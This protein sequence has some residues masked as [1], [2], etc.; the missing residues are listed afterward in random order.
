MEAI[1]QSHRTLRFGVFDVDLRTAELRKHG[2][3]IRLEEQPFH[4]LTLLLEC[5]GELVTREELRQRL[6]SADTFVDFDRSLNKAM[7]KLRLALGDSAESPRYIETLHRRGYRFIAPI[8]HDEPAGAHAVAHDSDPGLR[9][10]ASPS[11]LVPAASG[12]VAGPVGLNSAWRLRRGYWMAALTVV[13]V[14]V[15]TVFYL[16]ARPVTL[17]SSPGTVV[18][19]RSVAVLGFKNLS[20]RADQAWVSTALSDWLTTELA[21][22]EELRTISAESVARMRIEL[23]LP[24]ADSLGKD[25][26]AR[27][28]KNLGT[29]FVVV[30]S[31]A[32]L[33]QQS[34]GQVRLDLRL[35]DTR[36]GETID[37]VSE[38]GT[39]SRLFD[40]VSQAGEHLRTRLGVQGVTRQEAAEVAVALPTNHDAA[41]LYS[42][43][44]G[45]LRV[46][47]ALAARDLFAQAIATEPRYALS[48]AALATAWAT[49]GYD[50]NAR[51][52]AKRAF[53]LSSNLPR[54]ERLLVEG[55]YYETSKNWEKAIEIY[56][57]LVAFFP[58]SLDYGLA[59]AQAQ[60]SGG[61]GKD[62]LETVEALQKLPP[63]L[64][65]DPRIDLAESRAAE[66]LGDYR[67]DQVSC[68]RAAQKARALGASLLLAEARS[69][70]AWALSNLGSSDEAVQAAAEAKQIFDAADDQRGVAKAINLSGIALENKGDSLGAKKMYEQALATF[71]RIGNK[72][73]VANEL[74]DLGD[75]LLA[76]GDPNGARQKYEESLATNQEIANPDG[77]ALVK[78]ALG[79]VLLALGDHENA[80]KSC[81][82]SIEISRRIGDREKAAIG[83][84]CLGSAYRAEANFA[85]ARQHESEAIAIFDEIG[86]RQSSSRFQLE[87][88]ELSIDEHNCA[89]AAAIANRVIEEFSREN[90]LRDES[91]AHAVLS[92]A[93][94][95]QGKIQDARKAIDQSSA[96][97]EKYHDRLVE[98][99]T[100]ITAAR[101]RAASSDAADRAK[102]A[103]R[104]QQ[105]LTESDRTGLL[106]Y[107]FEARLALGE[108][109]M[110]NGNRAAGR[111]RLE[112]LRKDAND[113][114]F[115][116]IAQQAASAMTEATAQP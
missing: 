48:H 33:R 89:E 96:L 41:R 62:A 98:L 78:G 42:E 102:A 28:G 51:T 54:A 113:R 85:Q 59:L 115:G 13:V 30:G 104:L 7:S 17:A 91:L 83:M 34:G 93:M 53:E 64:G 14:A 82:E 76:L 108:L 40:L 37:A 9:A 100:A 47:D 114:G 46:F 50:E 21:A 24:D 111:G 88:A 110:N 66:S 27:I 105:V 60:V 80:K 73:G 70:Q 77:V 97:S 87:L 56:R 101:V 74:D 103:D 18:P 25:S 94:L 45:K 44:L 31:Y 4:I 38:T 52:E 112:S 3:R 69:D 92:Q 32:S 10:V 55:R 71:R 81:E 86:D 99:F 106:N 63:P 75:V 12:A 68:T 49:L 15:G 58:D 8:Q 20:G 29:D 5:P 26:L 72:L 19:R 2:V 84:A 11:A 90:A 39:E 57:A 6:W 107:A 65:D 36:N 35:Q 109:D 116:L 23:S 79:V 67:R 1:S 95:A 16:R 22:G 61:K 43:G